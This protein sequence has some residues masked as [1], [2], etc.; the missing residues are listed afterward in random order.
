MVDSEEKGPSQ[1]RPDQRRRE[2]E[3]RTKLERRQYTREWDGKERRRTPERRQAGDRRALIYGARHVTADPVAVIEEWLG[4][5][6]PGR[7]SVLLDSDDGSRRK[8]YLVMFEREEDKQ[9]FKRQVV[10]TG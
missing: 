7:W 9:A 8:A 2:I 6:C 3:R 4:E 10:D 1:H 5:H